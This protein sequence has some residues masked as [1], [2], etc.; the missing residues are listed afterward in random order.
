MDTYGTEEVGHANSGTRT[1]EQVKESAS[2][3]KDEA[4]HEAEALKRDVQDRS[5]EYFEDRKNF[6]ATELLDVAGALRA[7]AD[8]L[9]DQQHDHAGRY[10]K[11]AAAGL[12]RFADSL[13]ER[14]LGRLVDDA[15][16]LARRQPAAFIGG[17]VAAGFLLS[18][19]LKSSSTRTHAGADG[20]DRPVARGASS[21]GTEDTVRAARTSSPPTAPGD[22][23]REP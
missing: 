15:E 21:G 6:A 18:R 20:N 11:V 17:A 8:R 22:W 16:Q 2:R 12:E 4:M 3:L 9:G 13:R 19:F 7:S 10:V 5:K 1:R 23:D 14:D